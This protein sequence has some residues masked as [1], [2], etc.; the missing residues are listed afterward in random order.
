MGAATLL[1]LA[2]SFTAGCA[3]SGGSAQNASAAQNSSED[4]QARCRAAIA[5]VTR[6]CGAENAESGRCTDAKARSRAA[7]I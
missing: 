4:T 5:D 2:I 7:C 6:L 3:S 1:A